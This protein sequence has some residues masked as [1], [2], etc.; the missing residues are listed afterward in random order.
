MAKP[1]TKTPPEP[2]QLDVMVALIERL[3]REAHERLDRMIEGQS[4]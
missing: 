4:R 3:V 2:T 1:K